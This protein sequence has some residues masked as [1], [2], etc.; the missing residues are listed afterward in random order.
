M[1]CVTRISL[2]LCQV[3]MAVVLAACSAGSGDIGGNAGRQTSSMP[4]A[5]ITSIGHEPRADGAIVVRSGSEVV[6]SGKDSDDTD[7]P[8]T[9]FEWEGVNAPAQQLLAQKKVIWRT[10]STISFT[11]PLVDE[12]LAEFIFRLTVGNPRGER[13]STEIKVLV[14]RVLDADSFLLTDWQGGKDPNYFTVVAATGT[15]VGVDQL[16]G[17]DPRFHLKLQKIV[18]YLGRDDQLLAVPVGEAILIEGSWS[19]EYGVSGVSPD[20]GATALTS[21]RNPRYWFRIPALDAD[22]VN[23]LFQG[24]GGAPG[25]L[26]DPAR[27]DTAEVE[28]EITLTPLT[29]MPAPAAVV[30]GVPRSAGTG[31]R[32]VVAEVAGSGAPATVSVTRNRLLEELISAGFVRVESARTAREYYQAIDPLGKSDPDLGR[33]LEDW[34]RDNCFNPARPASLQ[35][36][37]RW[38]LGA[39][40]HATYTNNY[41][42]GFGRDMYFVSDCAAGERS[43]IVSAA[44]GASVSI[45][46]TKGERAAV[47]YNYPSLEAAIKRQGAFLAVAMEYRADS[48]DG[49][50]YARFYTFAPDPLTGKFVRVLSANFDGRGEKYTPGN[51]TVCH[52]G[53]PRFSYDLSATDRRGELGSVFLP[54]DVKA[55]LFADATSDS[56][57]RDNELREGY[58][59]QDQ[60]PSIKILNRLMLETLET[61]PAEHADIALRR[62]NLR[63]MV[64]GWYGGPGL[65]GSFTESPPEGWPHELYSH[66]IAQNCRSCHMQRVAEPDASG[67]LQPPAAGVPQFAHFD[68]DFDPTRQQRMR[69]RVFTEHVMPGSRLTADRFWVSAGSGAQPAADLLAQALGLESSSNAKPKVQAVVEVLR[70]SSPSESGVYAQGTEFVLSGLGSRFAAS[71]QWE[72][73]RS[74]GLVLVPIAGQGTATPGFRADVSGVYAL[75]LT[76]SDAT[77]RASVATENVVIDAKPTAGQFVVEQEL[78]GAPAQAVDILGPGSDVGD[79]FAGVAFLD[80]I[81]VTEGAELLDGPTVSSC[82]AGGSTCLVTIR[83]SGSLTLPFTIT[84]VDGDISG[85]GFIVLAAKFGPWAA[86]PLPNM[87]MDYQQVSVSILSQP[88]VLQQARARFGDDYLVGKVVRVVVVA[89]P[90]MAGRS[91]SRGSLDTGIADNQLTYTRPEKFVSTQTHSGAPV[92]D[93]FS[94]QL[95]IWEGTTLRQRSVAA[96]VDV[97]VNATPAS[98]LSSLL[99][100]GMPTGPLRSSC[101][102]CHTPERVANNEGMSWQIGTDQDTTWRQL[103]PTALGGDGVCPKSPPAGES[104]TGENICVNIQDPSESLLLRKPLV[105]SGVNHSATPFTD[106]NDDTY[107][108]I[109]QWL[110]EGAWN[111]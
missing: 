55:L 59:Q 106:T 79:G 105:G 11:A 49:R 30:V 34:L 74:N 29:P 12:E 9:L 90:V 62:S 47:V 38:E 87:N 19:P 108:K 64:E 66:G 97:L 65:P 24:V 43:A 72:V 60:E 37:Q 2:L 70:S 73:T 94:Y 28:Y 80:P 39:D 52:G 7:D 8:L 77:G 78:V 33:T 27:I 96:Q 42:L 93:S 76:V 50:R 17:A 86:L 71:Y 4:Q 13:H 63:E 51:C 35:P 25:K 103:T 67:G 102:G 95:E 68:L 100:G 89:D 92:P 36:E 41:D 5:V 91:G 21:F 45:D 31:E 84:D 1:R 83:A 69:D 15:S 23:V 88:Q 46:T 3:G 54:W 101:G 16:V 18:R 40:A 6:L 99:S 75:K 32:L 109:L 10:S 110:E 22:E 107:K 44:P 26:L 20:A 48:P 61:Q 14:D 82:A 111:N 56:S 104:T 81:P 57:I 98:R 85:Q 53:K 58:L